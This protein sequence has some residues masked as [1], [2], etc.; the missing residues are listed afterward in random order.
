MLQAYCIQQ[1]LT[2]TVAAA[3][4]SILAPHTHVCSSILAPHT[5]MYLPCMS[6]H[7][8][9][10]HVSTHQQLCPSCLCLL[11]RTAVCVLCCAVHRV[12]VRCSCGPHSTLGAA[13][14]QQTPRAHSKPVSH[15]GL[16]HRGHR[17]GGGGTGR[18]GHREGGGTGRR[19]TERGAGGGT[20]HRQGRVRGEGAQAGGAQ[21]EEGEGGREGREAREVPHPALPVT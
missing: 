3:R 19:G 16:Q 17:Q 2:L 5:H 14:A 12:S 15:T 18:G 8:H 6:T 9:T 21:G 10:P 7:A 20:G 13:R 1:C 11:L 4:S